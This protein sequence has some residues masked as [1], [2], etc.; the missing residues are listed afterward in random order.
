MSCANLHSAAKHASQARNALSIGL[1]HP[2]PCKHKHILGQL[3]ELGVCSMQIL[4]RSSNRAWGYFGSV[5]HFN[6]SGTSPLWDRSMEYGSAEDM[7]RTPE[8]KTRTNASPH[9]KNTPTGSL[10]IPLVSLQGKLSLAL[11][12][13]F[14]A[15]VRP[16]Q[17]TKASHRQLGSDT[18]RRRTNLRSQ[19]ICI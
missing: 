12:T 9:T 15:L 3:G 6:S 11:S 17:F 10:E 5:K 14:S 1:A 13:S 18:V 2:G 7:C 8:A 4:R 19:V 16:W